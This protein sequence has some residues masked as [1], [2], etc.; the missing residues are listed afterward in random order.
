MKKVYKQE[1][2]KWYLERSI[3]LVAGIFVIFSV[4]MVLLGYFNFIYF[5][6]FVGAMLLIF[7]TTRY[8]PMAILFKKCGINE[9]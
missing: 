1:T 9:K 5:T 7:S 3:F 2:S 8:C 4:V 6:L